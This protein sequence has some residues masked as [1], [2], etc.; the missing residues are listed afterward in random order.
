VNGRVQW[1][2]EEGKS[3]KQI[4]DEEAAGIE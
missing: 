1:K 4:E 2:T 3:L